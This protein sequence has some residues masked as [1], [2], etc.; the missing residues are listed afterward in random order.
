MVWWFVA[1]KHD[2]EHCGYR[3]H[4]SKRLLCVF[5]FCW[6]CYL[7]LFPSSSEKTL[8]APNHT[9]DFQNKVTPQLDREDNLS[10]DDDEKIQCEACS[11]SIPHNKILL[12]LQ[13]L[14]H[15]LKLC[16]ARL[17]FKEQRAVLTGWLFFFFFF[18]HSHQ[19]STTP[20][21]SGNMRKKQNLKA[22]GIKV[23]IT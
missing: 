21:S 7:H 14:R 3:V 12:L 9:K 23:I 11:V 16:Q 2:D 5:L 15:A 22:F 20:S 17:K 10:C 4:R 6:C 13:D 8:P 18:L 19:T 1:E